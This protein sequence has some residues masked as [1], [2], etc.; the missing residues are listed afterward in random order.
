MRKVLEAIFDGGSLLPWARALRR[1]PDLRA[2]AAR[3]RARRRGREPA[4]AARRGARR[5]GARKEAAFI[6]LCDTFNMPLVFLQDVPGLMIGSEAERAGIL[7]GY[8]QRRRA[9]RP[10]EGAEGRGRRAQGLRR[11]PLR[12][13]RPADPPGPAAR[14]ADRRARLHGA[15]DRRAHRRTGGGSRRRSRRR[16]RQA[17]RRAGRRARRRV[18]ARVRALGGRRA[19]LPRRRHRP[20]PDP[21]GG[22]HRDRL[23]LGQRPAASAPRARPRSATCPADRSPTSA[24]SSATSTRRS[25]TGRRSSASSTPAQLERADRRYDHFEAGRGRDGVGDLRQPGGCE[26]QLLCPLNDGPLGR[27]LAKRGEGVH[28]ICFTAPD[29]P[30]AVERAGREGRRS[31]PAT[32]LSQ[33]PA[34]CRGSTGPSSRPSEP[35]PAGRGRLPVQAG[36]RALGAG[37]LS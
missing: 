37:R 35:R 8:E 1:Q 7:A 30:G 23:R 29:L 11:R 24:S 36:R 2:R 17:R 13:G 19:L 34:A 25:R 22:R 20:A 4:D 21:R 3:G 14:L 32:E 18:G 9:A 12:A 5:A 33:D 6:D 15:R 26:I 16:A 27:R 10:R 31:S 28:H